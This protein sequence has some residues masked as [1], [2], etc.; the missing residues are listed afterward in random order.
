MSSIDVYINYIGITIFGCEILILIIFIIIGIKRLLK[1][2]KY[3]NIEK[4]YLSYSNLESTQLQ[5]YK[6]DKQKW[7]FTAMLKF[8]I[9]KIIVLLHFS[10]IIIYFLPYFR[11]GS[12]LDHQYLIYG[13]IFTVYCVIN[14]ISWLISTRLF[15]KEFRIYKDQSY[16]AIRLFWII[17]CI[18]NIIELIIALIIV[19]FNDKLKERIIDKIKYNILLFSYIFLISKCFFSFILFLLAIFR[20]YDVS[21]VKITKREEIDNIDLNETTISIGVK[22][23]LINNSEDE[24]ANEED[25]SFTNMDT[26]SIELNDSEGFNKKKFD[27]ELK[28]QTQDFKQLIFSLKIE[29]V[30]HKRVKLPITVS[31]FNEAIIKSYTNKDLSKDL[32]NLIKQ[33]YNISLTLNP[34]RTSFTGEK[35]NANLLAHLYREIIK[36][37]HKFLL[38]LLDFLKIKSD[39][40]INCLSENF[41]SIYK[42]NPNIEQDIEKIDTFGSIFDDIGFIDLSNTP[43]IKKQNTSG[44]I[45]KSSRFNKKNQNANNSMSDYNDNDISVNSAKIP[46]KRN[47]I[48]KDY[49]SFSSF[50]NSILINKRYVTIQ[51]ISYQ[52]I[53]RNLNILIKTKD[54][55]NDLTLELNIDKIHDILYDD[56]LAS[57]IIDNSEEINDKQSNSKKI[58]EE[59][60][61][62]YLNNII[63]YDER[64]Y[65]LFNLNELLQTNAIKFNYD[66]IKNF[67]EEKKSHIGLFKKDI[68]LYLFDIKMKLY[69]KND[70]L[71]PLINESNIEIK[72]SKT[73]INDVTNNNKKQI[74]CTINV[75]KFYL[76]IEDIIL[77]LNKNIIGYNELSTTLNNIKIY[78]GKLLNII[79]T[80]PEDQLKNIKNYRLKEPAHGDRKI[81]LIVEE[82][83]KRY[84]KNKVKMNIVNQELINDINKEIKNLNNSMNLLMNKPN[85]KYVLYFT[86]FRDLIEFN[87][88]F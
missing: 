76:I 57:Y 17:I 62:T 14:C 41:T 47:L 43:I 88:L 46:V 37:E 51:V 48:P 53:S 28:I 72:I 38:D 7:T 10:S 74:N 3:M 1:I 83:E 82:F 18:I 21:I 26:F 50:Y 54:N 32:L 4:K 5:L 78:I 81:N 49:V 6:V 71:K 2:K 42:E 34:Q 19:F 52:E 25:L 22:E 63:Y 24:F 67:F 44:K 68:R 23:E 11:S 70:D 73:D 35:K 61:N 9:N 86:G 58:M 64:L 56:E 30:K 36:I 66:I 85:L 65:K 40:L 12:N 45:P 27:I 60:F 87:T 13:L 75:I 59:L 8:I 29:K 69:K 79:Y 20:P 15:Y 55:K 33:A 77:I 16:I 39:D 84:S 80:V 31:N